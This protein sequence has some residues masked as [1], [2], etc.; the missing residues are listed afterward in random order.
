V[1]VRRDR[2]RFSLWRS[3]TSSTGH[4]EALTDGPYNYS[5]G[6]LGGGSRPSSA[7]Q[8]SI[9]LTTF[10]P[11]L[12]QYV[13]TD[14][15]KVIPITADLTTNRWSGTTWRSFSAAFVRRCGILAPR[16]GRPAPNDTMERSHRAPRLTKPSRRLAIPN[17][18]FAAAAAT[19]E[20]PPPSIAAMRQTRASQRDISPDR[21]WPCAKT[22]RPHAPAGRQ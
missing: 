16:G 9:I 1:S 15:C 2:A 14:F 6:E 4:P 10:D 18:S 19:T 11:R 7:K 3:K 20:C 12:H 8:T 13:M 22:Y 21:S 17:S 5:A